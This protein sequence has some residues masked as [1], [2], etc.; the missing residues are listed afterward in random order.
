MKCNYRLLLLLILFLGSSCQQLSKWLDITPNETF[1]T[2]VKKGQYCEINSKTQIIGTNNLAIKQ[3]NQ[4]I[5]Q[6]NLKLD[7]FTKSVL[8]SLFQLDT[9]PDQTAP[10]SRF[11]IFLYDG[12]KW[13]YRDFND[14]MIPG[15]NKANPYI[16]GLRWLSS[17][18]PNKSSL[19]SLAKQLD[20]TIPKYVFVGPEFAKWLE[21]NK[22]T[23]IKYDV[24]REHYFK[25]DQIVVYGES[26]LSLNHS[27][28]I[29]KYRSNDRKANIISQLP[30]IQKNTQTSVLNYCNFDQKLYENMIFSK[31]DPKRINANVFGMQDSQGRVFIGIS[32]LK[33]PKLNPDSDQFL[34]EAEN[35]LRPVPICLVENAKDLFTIIGNQGIDPAQHLVQL[36]SLSLE[37]SEGLPGLE[38]R[39]MQARSLFLVNP[40]RVAVETQLISE[41]ELAELHHYNIPVYHAD[42]LGEVW[43][44]MKSL[45]TTGFVADP[46]FERGVLCL[47]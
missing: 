28:L 29:K 47:P 23:Y 35:P 11:Q 16:D 25:G 36:Q 4:E 2:F 24:F 33:N 6:K 27:S 34:L 13:L 21:N 5:L 20:N 41:R 46:R 45:G 12:N 40:A 9:R 22:S 31:N 39:L 17:L 18:T 8:L 30:F 43:S 44:W 32:S 15:Q 26:V 10:D 37:T 19:E 3:F 14:V 42:Q 38:Q 1:T 7:F